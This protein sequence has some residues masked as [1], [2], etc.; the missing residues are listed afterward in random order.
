M[1][2]CARGAAGGDDVTPIV[3][4]I[5]EAAAERRPL[6]VTSAG[7]WLSAGHPVDAGDTLS[8]ADHAGIVEYV[9]GDLTLTARAGTTLSE[10]TAATGANDQWLPLD[11]WGGDDGTLG[12]T[13]ATATAGPHAHSMGLPRDVVLGVEFVTGT[14]QVVRAGGRVVKNVAGFDLTRLIT[15]S[16]GTLGVIVEATVRLRARPQQTRTLV[17]PAQ[18]TRADL[19][20]LAMQLRALPFTPLA[21]ELVN[22]RLAAHLELGAHACL[23]V[24]VGGNAHSVS[25]QLDRL[26]ELGVPT[27]ASETV[28]NTLRTAERGAVASWRW[29]NL[30]SEF[31]ETWTAADVATRP[32]EGGGGAF[33]H[34]NPARGVVRVAVM[35]PKATPA[36]LAQAASDFHGTIAIEQLPPAAW[37]LLPPSSRRSGLSRAIREK[38]DPA[39]VLNPGIMEHEMGALA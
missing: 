13:L 38:F 27:D 33:I 3:E 28:W 8:L 19:S 17:I 2:R 37:S 5:R 15:G 21:S 34:G 1:A 29:S 10:I 6:R 30:P 20:A 31:G 24:R 25:A 23:L 32:L 39:G 35:Q 4:R 7:T 12:A 22:A 18:T 16:W 14:A 11:P 36:K 9:P 26:R